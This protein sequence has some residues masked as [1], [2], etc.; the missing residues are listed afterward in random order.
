MQVRE[1]DMKEQ[2]EREKEREADIGQAMIDRQTC[3]EGERERQTHI[4][5]FSL[6]ET[7]GSVER[8][9]GWRKVGS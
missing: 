1:T 7:G 3:R 2:T 5:Q 6:M 8:R 9:S 4:L